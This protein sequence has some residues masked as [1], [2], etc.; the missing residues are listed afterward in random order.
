MEAVVLIF[1]AL[2]LLGIVAAAV[3]VIGVSFSSSTRD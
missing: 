2:S 3:M 1:F